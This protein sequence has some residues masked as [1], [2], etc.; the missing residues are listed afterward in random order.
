MIGTWLLYAKCMFQLP[1]HCT[2]CK[3]SVARLRINNFVFQ[4]SRFL[5]DFRISAKFA[6]NNSSIVGIVTWPAFPN[7][8]CDSQHRSWLFIWICDLQLAP[9]HWSVEIIT[10]F[11]TA[12]ISYTMWFII[13]RY[14][15]I[16]CNCN[17]QKYQT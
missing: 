3:I 7:F 17:T 11:T 10:L 2:I 1:D 15:D 14:F 13:F 5:L 8:K 12:K 6:I 16:F 9:M 4:S